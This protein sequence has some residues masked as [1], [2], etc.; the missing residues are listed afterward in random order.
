[1]PPVPGGAPPHLDPSDEDDLAELI[2]LAHP[3]LAAVIDAGEDVA[4]IDGEPVNARLHLLA[5]QVV[6]ER[7]LHDDPP[8][9][10]LAFESLLERGVDPHE[11]QHAIG[12]R[13]V[14][15][16]MEQF[17][18]PP[19]PPRTRLESVLAATAGRDGRRSAPLAAGTGA[20]AAPRRRG[21]GT[22]EASA[23]RQRGRLGRDP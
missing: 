8:E 4:V 22:S 18:P 23:P 9:D 2:R 10:W 17:G 20:D 13:F 1:M 21:R 7:L 12:Q 6:A 19:R 15:G 14:E 16:L 11:A 5:H 3:D